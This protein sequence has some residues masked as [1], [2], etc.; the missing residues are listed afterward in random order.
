MGLTTDIWNEITES[1]V[2]P[3]AILEGI[4]ERISDVGYDNLEEIEKDIAELHE[5]QTGVSLALSGPESTIDGALAK[6]ENGLQ[7]EYN[8]Q[9]LAKK[10]SKKQE[11]LET[12]KTKLNNQI[13][14]RN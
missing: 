10:I 11:Q 6:D 5:E 2:I 1:G 7:G 12:L 3:A 14:K 13:Y 9:D 8:N 4:K